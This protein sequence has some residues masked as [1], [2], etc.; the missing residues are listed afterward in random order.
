MIKKIHQQPFAFKIV[1]T[2]SICALLF[3]QLQVRFIQCSYS[4]YTHSG[5]FESKFHSAVQN[6]SVEKAGNSEENRKGYKKFNRRFHLSG[7]FILPSLLS[8]T[9]PEPGGESVLT[10]YNAPFYKKRYAFVLQLRG[11]PSVLI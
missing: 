9:Q 2:V 6:S 10:N 8:P 11:P 3:V 7:S 4:N 1:L 5:I